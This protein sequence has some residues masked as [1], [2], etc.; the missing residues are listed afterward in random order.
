MSGSSRSEEG[1]TL[2]GL[3]EAC[4]VRLCLFLSDRDVCM[5]EVCCKELRRVGQANQIWSPRVA[6]CLG[7][8][9]Q[10]SQRI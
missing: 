6:D 8:P 3:P 9:A 5:L 4:I 2:L 7:V 1:F 10:A